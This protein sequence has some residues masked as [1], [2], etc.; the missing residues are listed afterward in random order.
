M[1]TVADLERLE[2]LV[3]LLDP[4]AK[5]K[6]GQ[7]IS[8][9]AW[10]TLVGSMIELAR[11]VVTHE[12]NATVADHTHEEQVALSWLDTKLRNM[13]QGGALADPTNMRRVIELERR[14]STVADRTDEAHRNVGEVRTRLSEVATRDL[15]R[16]SMLTTVGRKVDTMADGRTDVADLRV[17]LDTIKTDVKT[18]VDAAQKFTINGQIADIAQMAA[19][20]SSL[21]ELKSRLTTPAGD[22]LDAAALEKRLTELTNTLVDENELADVLKGR[23]PADMV[24]DFSKYKDELLGDLQQTVKEEYAN[25][26]GSIK[27]DVLAAIPDVN[28]VVGK[29]MDTRFETLA[30]VE[31]AKIDDRVASLVDSRLATQWQATVDQRVSAALSA[32]KAELVSQIKATVVD[33]LKMQYTAPAFDDDLS[34]VRGIGEVYNEKLNRAGIYSYKDLAA[35]TPTQLAKILGLTLATVQKMQLI[36]QAQTLASRVR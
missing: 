11:S 22:L 28:D 36:E 34:A 1:A 8:A 31:L 25:A 24:P 23:L 19:R 7:P 30:A 18:A 9:D 29:A 20:I 15:V 17:T 2:A 4:L 16:Q 21:E 12:R 10:N 27:N 13:V 3:T 6:P 35:Q 5:V 26:V 32:A 14:V 33:E